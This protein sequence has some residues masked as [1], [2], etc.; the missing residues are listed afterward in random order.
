MLF[1]DLKSP[2]VQDPNGVLAST[3]VIFATGLPAG[4]L[5]P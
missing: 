2:L 4:I 1:S 3:L 5:I